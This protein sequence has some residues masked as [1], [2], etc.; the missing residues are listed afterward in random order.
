[1]TVQCCV[2]KKVKDDG[3]WKLENRIHRTDVSH[4][5]CPI[6]LKASVA[7]MAVERQRADRAQ[8]VG[9]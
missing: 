5:Y 2:C 7:N 4:T 3:T 6:C 8:P 1:M 9:A